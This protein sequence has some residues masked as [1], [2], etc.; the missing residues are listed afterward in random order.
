MF[1]AFLPSL[2]RRLVDPAFVRALLMVIAIARILFLVKK[3]PLK[4]FSER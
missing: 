1:P 4:T 2:L 3:M